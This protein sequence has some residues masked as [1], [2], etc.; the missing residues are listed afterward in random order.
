MKLSGIFL[1]ATHGSTWYI[2]FS[3]LATEGRD[4]MCFLDPGDLAI[5][6]MTR[7]PVFHT[8]CCIV[9]G[10]TSGLL[11]LFTECQCKALSLGLTWWPG[12]VQEGNKS[13]PCESLQRL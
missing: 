12:Q 2:F 6:V 13:V 5:L 4:E 9:I 11:S 7:D 10:S 8:S 3:F 1:R